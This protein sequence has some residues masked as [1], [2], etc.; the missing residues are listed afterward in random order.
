MKRTIL[1]VIISAAVFSILY[2]IIFMSI[3]KSR[4][5][6]EFFW[7]SRSENPFYLHKAF[8]ANNIIDQLRFLIPCFVSSFSGGILGSIVLKKRNYLILPIPMI[9]LFS[10]PY[11]MFII[12]FQSI[13]KEQVKTCIMSDFIIFLSCVLGVWLTSKIKERNLVSDL[14]YIRSGFEIIPRIIKKSLLGLK[15]L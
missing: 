10:L 13:Y 2:P 6:A 15:S 9:A 5:F 4:I 12:P 1:A 7:Y 8:I 14:I 3:M 11:L